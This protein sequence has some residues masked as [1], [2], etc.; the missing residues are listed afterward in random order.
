MET[1]KSTRSWSRKAWLMGAVSSVV[2]AS[3]SG[4]MTVEYEIPTDV[5]PAVGVCGF[6]C[7]PKLHDTYD[8]PNTQS[9]EMG[10][11]VEIVGWGYQWNGGSDYSVNKNQRTVV[12]GAPG[13]VSALGGGT[14]RLHLVPANMTTGGLK[15]SDATAIGPASADVR[16]LGYSLLATDIRQGYTVLKG[17]IGS[18]SAANQAPS[19]SQSARMIQN[20]AIAATAGSVESTQAAL[21]DP[22]AFGEE[23]LAGAPGSYSNAG[24]V[25]WYENQG[26]SWTLGG[27]LRSPSGVAGEQ[28]GSALAAPSDLD[29]RTPSDTSTKSPP[30]IA[31]GAPGSNTV[32][33]FDVFPMFDQ[34]MLP[35]QVITA[36]SGTVKG[37]AFGA[38]LVIA[39]FN[40]DGLND[41]AVGAP[42]QTGGGRVY[43]YFGQAGFAPVAPVA[44]VVAPIAPMSAGGEFGFALAAGKIRRAD[45]DR[46]ALVVGAPGFDDG[47]SFDSGGLCQL[48]FGNASAGSPI[49]WQRCDVNP[50][51]G[52]AYRYGHA[53]AV[54]NFRATN[55]SGSTSSS[56]ATGAE[57]AVGIP[58]RPSSLLG[59]GCVKILEQ[60]D[61]GAEPAQS[62]SLI[63]G[64]RTGEQ[65]G[66]ALAADYIEQN[67]HE[68]LAI[69]APLFDSDRG[70]VSVTKAE[71]LGGS[72]DPISGKWK[73]YDSAGNP[74]SVNVTWDSVAATLNITMLGPA[75]LT[76]KKGGSVCSIFG[77]DVD[78]SGTTTFPTI[79]WTTTAVTH[80]EH[81]A[82]DFSGYDVE[83]DVTYDAA[84]DTFKLDVDEQAGVL[85]WMSNSCHIVNN[86]FVFTQT[87]ANTCD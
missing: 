37:A 18:S 1:T 57:V 12:A 51:P 43:V 17:A 16:E 21:S 66:R 87:S 55:G 14:G 56:C 26:G 77:T 81:V 72:S 47:A 13:Y 28:F 32:Y 23:L 3:S 22:V 7:D 2:A 64:T 31:V 38:S 69:G 42:Y 10:Y 62:G 40:Q 70:S 44:R 53:V 71:S 75:R 78:V 74:F 84:A 20:S 54:G 35:A 59:A 46:P 34:P 76:A 19:N 86:P 30:W 11:A 82:L 52:I 5:D 83:A 65:L 8:S 60:S 79:S 4:C 48:Q 33:I 67:I 29:T 50:T 85:G 49:T 15:N 27:E 9:G 45:P 63:W 6:T 36:P 39:D 24:A 58:G 61:Q 68:D 25:E 80:T 41:L 73:S